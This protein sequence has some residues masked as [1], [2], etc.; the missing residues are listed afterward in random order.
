MLK[1]EVKK[2]DIGSMKTALKKFCLD[3]KSENILNNSSIENMKIGRWE[4]EAWWV[5]FHKDKII[6][7]SGCYQEPMYGESSW[8]V[9]VRSATL[10]QFRGMAG[11]FSKDL[12]HDFCWGAMLPL[13]KEY[14]VQHQAKKI[15]FTTNSS[16]DGDPHSVRTN[17]F[18]S[19]VLL[20]N[21]RVRLFKGDVD[22]Y[23]VKQNI[24][25]IV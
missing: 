25:E 16:D 23:N 22:H 13:Q 15:F 7:A 24:W 18:V 10:R 17:R 21:K 3:C 4:K 9:L 11:Q 14:A 2:L 5:V 12:N 8:R 20:K 6:S 19:T 1:F